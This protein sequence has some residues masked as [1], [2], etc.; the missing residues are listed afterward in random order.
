MEEKK[1]TK[2]KP[3][4]DRR[5]G[6]LGW[7]VTREEPDKDFLPDLKSQWMQL[8]KS[9]RFK[10]IAGAIVGAALFIGSL[11]LVYLLLSTMVR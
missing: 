4:I 2:E 11:V 3:H 9:E 6:L 1:G 5:K 7:F 10:F 8:D